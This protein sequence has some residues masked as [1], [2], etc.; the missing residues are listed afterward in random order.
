MMPVVVPTLALLLVSLAPAQDT[1]TVATYNVEN[2][3]DNHDDPYKPDEGTSPKSHVEIDVLA[4]TIDQLAADVLAL[5]EVENLGVLQQLNARL[6]RSYAFVELLPSNDMRGIHTAL[7]SRVRIKRAIGHRFWSLDGDRVFA[8]DVP[9][10]QLEP[11]EGRTLLVAPVHFKSKRTVG[12]DRQGA[13]WRTAEAAGMVEI[14]QDLRTQG[15]RAP[16]VLAGDLNDEPGSPSLAPLFRQLADATRTV[17]ADQRW[18]Y[19]YQN[20]R[21]Q[22]DYILYDGDLE[23]KVARFVH[24][25]DA[26]SDH[27]PIVVAFGWP[28]RIRRFEGPSTIAPVD[29]EH[30]PRI[31]ATDT[32]RLRRFLLRE[33]E[34]TGTVL[35]VRPTQRGGHYNILFARDARDAVSG[36][37]PQHAV[38]R[39]DDLNRLRGK[40]VVLKGPVFLYRGRL[41]IKLTRRRQISAASENR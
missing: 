28:S 32:A 39:F 15:L 12:G 14:L 33:V 6:A 20:R 19:V 23:P 29:P 24:E 1:L 2:L 36:F 25:K 21:Q 3:F 5:Q 40:K 10:Y 9:V 22:I 41:E 38:E 31:G 35:A 26:A 11:S 18:S 16:F 30:R 4:A 37:V 27:A 7:L 13:A 8:R 17:D 34:V